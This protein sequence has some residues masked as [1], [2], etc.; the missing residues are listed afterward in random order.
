MICPVLAPNQKRASTFVRSDDRSEARDAEDPTPGASY[1]PG[2]FPPQLHPRTKIIPPE[3]LTEELDLTAEPP[4]PFD[5]CVPIEALLG[6][7]GVTPH[8]Q[9][10]T[11]IRPGNVPGGELWATERHYRDAITARLREAGRPDLA[12]PLAR[13]HEEPVYAR[14]RGCHKVQVFTKRCDRHYCPLCQ[15]SLTLKR[16]ESVHWWASKLKEPKHVVL[17]VRNIHDLTP[18]HI[19]ELKQ[20]LG[21]LRRNVLCRKKTF[22]RVLNEDDSYVRCKKWLPPTSTHHTIVSH[23]WKGGFYSLQITN[24]GNG[25][26]PHVHLLLDTKFIFLPALQT[27]WLA[28]NRGAGD[29][30]RVFDCRDSARHREAIRYVSKPS[31]VARWSGSKIAEFCDALE[32]QRCFGVFGSLFKLR[33]EWRE[34]LDTLQ[35]CRPV[36]DCGCQ[37]WKFF[38]QN[39]WDA[40][41][42]RI[43]RALARPPPAVKTFSPVPNLELNFN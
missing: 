31:S 38:S 12:E 24:T 35:Y 8:A 7:R 6:N 39:E 25:W 32:G 15:P 29:N 11:S 20:W 10:T 4:T 13:C 22:W 2:V 42:L 1:A 40:E 34:F 41:Q 19:T 9:Q 36:C 28:V 23:P 33:A 14:C 26:H 16:L 18:A 5:D 17:T 27:A 30:V 43:D 37:S 3:G 21:K